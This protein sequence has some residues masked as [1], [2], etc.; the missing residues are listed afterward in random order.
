MTIDGMEFP[1]KIRRQKVEEHILGTSS[2]KNRLKNS[3]NRKPPSAFL[4]E[5]D[6][7]KLVYQHMG[8]NNPELQKEKDEAREF[9]TADHVIGIDQDKTGKE[10]ETKRMWIACGLKP[11]KAKGFIWLERKSKAMS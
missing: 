5:E 3:N 9:F 4:P 10:Q 11:G 8:K 7:E 2:Y 1:I 6:V